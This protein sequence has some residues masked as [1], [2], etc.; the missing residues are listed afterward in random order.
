[1]YTPVSPLPIL[2]LRYSKAS[3]H[4]TVR[5]LQWLL[6]PKIDTLFCFGLAQSFFVSEVMKV[7]HWGATLAAANH[8]FPF[9]FMTPITWFWACLT[10][11][12]GIRLITRHAEINRVSFRSSPTR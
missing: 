8:E 12:S 2:L 10:Y 1:M 6:R 3:A 7:T 5:V 11:G 9:R 4:F